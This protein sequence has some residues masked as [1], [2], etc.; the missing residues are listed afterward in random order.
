MVDC[1]LGFAKGI[2]QSRKLLLPRTV[3]DGPES[4]VALEITAP[5]SFL[6]KISTHHFL[7]H[8]LSLPSS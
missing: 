4:D 3:I 7:T 8:L 1:A 6:H 5:Q 2:G